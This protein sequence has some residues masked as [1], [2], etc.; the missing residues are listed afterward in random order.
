M[1]YMSEWISTRDRLPEISERS[2]INPSSQRVLV[3]DGKNIQ[4]GVRWRCGKEEYFLPDFRED[5][6]D[7]THWMPLPEVPNE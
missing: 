5:F 6:D 3:T 1:K 2:P 7:I 4:V